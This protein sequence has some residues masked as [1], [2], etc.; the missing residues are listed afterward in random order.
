MK[1]RNERNILNLK[2]KLIKEELTINIL[3]EALIINNFKDKNRSI[4]AIIIIIIIT[5]LRWMWKILTTL[6]KE[7]IY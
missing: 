5:C 4:L 7:E 3:E 1:T 6:I 2:T